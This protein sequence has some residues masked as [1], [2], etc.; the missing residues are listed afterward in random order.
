MWS[1]IRTKPTRDQSDLSL[2]E[3]SDLTL[4][5]LEAFV[6]F[7]VGAQLF[8]FYTGSREWIAILVGLGL[9]SVVAYIVPPRPKLWKVLLTTA[10]IALIEVVLHLLHVSFA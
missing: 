5:S 8:Q 3:Q 10:L 2:K 4:K 9:W 1:S 7:I 6:A